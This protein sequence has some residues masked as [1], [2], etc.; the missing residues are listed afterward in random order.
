MFSWV[1]SWRTN[2][3]VNSLPGV[4]DHVDQV[5]FLSSA[6]QPVVLARVPLH[7]FSSATSPR[8]P[9]VHRLDALPASAPQ[10]RGHH[11]LPQR[12][13]A[14][15][16]AVFALQILARQRRSEASIYVLREDAHRFLT[17]LLVQTPVGLASPQPVD[18]GLVAALFQFRQQAPDLAL[19]NAQFHGR[20]PLRNQFLLCLLEHH[21]SIA[22][23][24]VH[25]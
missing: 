1:E 20:L 16:Q 25:G 14:D 15:L 2:R 19:G 3:A 7:Q 23:A 22:I 17:G 6:L 24:L 12:F 10:S 21:Q 11:E 18:Y 8:S 9:L 4:V 5:Q 13:A